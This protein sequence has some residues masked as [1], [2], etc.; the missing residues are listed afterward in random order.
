MFTKEP[1]TAPVIAP[2]K[3]V[4]KKDPSRINIPKPKQNPGPTRA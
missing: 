2:P 3:T 4:P 1:H